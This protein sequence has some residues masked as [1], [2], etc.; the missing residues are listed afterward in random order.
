MNTQH[1]AWTG[2]VISQQAPKKISDIMKK[3]PTLLRILGAGALIIAMYSFL[4][5]GW[6][7]GN[8]VFR[9]LLMLGHTGILAAIGLASGH[10]LKESKGARLLLTLALVSVPANFAILGAFI[11][12]QTTAVDIAQ[13]PHYVAW[14]VESLNTALLASGGAM[15]ILVPI[16]LLGFTV[17]AR[18]MSKKLSLL[19]LCSNAALLLP[20]RDPQLIGMLVLALTS[21]TI[22]FSRK[23]AHNHTAAKTQEG[24]T[25]LGLQL[26]PLAVLMG[27]SLW[28]YSVDLFLMTV[29]SITVFFI[30]RQI[31]L[32]LEPGSK[33][34]NVLDGLSLFPAIS[35]TLWF[36]AA[37]NETAFVPEALAIP[38][39]A[40]ASAT[41]VYDLSRRSHKNT[42]FFRSIAVGGL[43]LCIIANLLF[44]TSLLAA[45]ASAVIGFM[46]LVYGYKVQ[47]RSLFTGGIVLMI[48]GISQQL[49]ELVHHFDLGG[50]A[51]LAT[52]G[53]VAIVAASVMESQGGKFKPRLESWKEKF[54]RWEK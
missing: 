11:F 54:H 48:A 38:L 50:W 7:S 21:F 46:L 27:R 26:L 5:K 31:S 10:W 34:R 12:S 2:E 45:L 15:L 41:M 17:L 14:T 24:V 16:T 22:I 53:I 8:D 35:S 32:Y 49:Y 44:L 25:A 6:E 36:S 28:L 30:L 23:T 9:Y 19:F 20:L 4:A 52:L 37:L 51:S 43:V 1:D 42:D 40:F 29:L 39:G 33:L 3:L 13:Y 18:S 47:Q